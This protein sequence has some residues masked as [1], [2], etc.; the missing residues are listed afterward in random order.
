MK[1]RRSGAGSLGFE[2]LRN[3]P[4]PPPSQTH[5]QPTKGRVDAALEF[6]VPVCRNVY[7]MMQLGVE[8][9][10]KSLISQISRNRD[11]P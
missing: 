2:A 9:G 6:R 4:V 1:G 8:N 5:E 10:D 3:P 7:F 11:F